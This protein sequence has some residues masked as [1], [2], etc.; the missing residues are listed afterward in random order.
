ML[1]KTAYYVYFWAVCK[2]QAYYA[3]N[4]THTT[5]HCAY[6]MTVLSKFQVLT[7]LLEYYNLIFVNI[8]WYE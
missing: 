2:D 6:E 4:Y 3:Q 5:P 8:Q 7:A 1:M